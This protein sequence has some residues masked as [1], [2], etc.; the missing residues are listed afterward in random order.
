MRSGAA[1][2]AGATL[3]TLNERSDSTTMTFAAFA[4]PFGSA[5]T[6]G[7]AGSTQRQRRADS[8]LQREQRGLLSPE[9][10]S[11]DSAATRAGS[12]LTE[13]SNPKRG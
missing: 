11:L 3:R 2:F 4:L 1:E 5:A 12:L 9:T 10:S 6:A 13:Q 8:G 7:L